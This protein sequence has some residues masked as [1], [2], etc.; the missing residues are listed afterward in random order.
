M[1]LTIF[2]LSPAMWS[3]ATTVA[4]AVLGTPCGDVALWSRA[5]LPCLERGQLHNIYGDRFE[6]VAFDL[7]RAGKIGDVQKAE[8]FRRE[9]AYTIESLGEQSEWTKIA[10]KGGWA[11]S[12]NTIF[13]EPFPSIEEQFVLSFEFCR[14]PPGSCILKG[15]EVFLEEC[16]LPNHF[17]LRGIQAL[18]RSYFGAIRVFISNLQI[19]STQSHEVIMSC[20][21]L[22]EMGIDEYGMASSILFTPHPMETMDNFERYYGELMVSRVV[23]KSLLKPAGWEMNT[24]YLVTCHIAEE[25]LSPEDF[26]FPSFGFFREYLATE[27][28]FAGL[29]G[30]SIALDKFQRKLNYQ[31]TVRTYFPIYYSVSPYDILKGV[32]ERVETLKPPVFP[33]LDLIQR[34]EQAVFER[35]P[36][37]NRLFRLNFDPS[38]DSD[39]TW[40]AALEILESDLPITGPLF[41]RYAVT[42]DRLG[43]WRAVESRMIELVHK[44][45][46]P[47]DLSDPF[48]MIAIMRILG[49]PKYAPSDPS[50]TFSQMVIAPLAP[51]VP[52]PQEPLTLSV[53]KQRYSVPPD[54][55][56]HAVL[57]PL[58]SEMMQAQPLEVLLQSLLARKNIPN[59]TRPVKEILN[60]C[61]ALLDVHFQNMQLPPLELPTEI[62]I[63]WMKQF[64]KPPQTE[65][66]N[67]Q[68]PFAL[69]VL[70]KLLVRYW[71]QDESLRQS[72]AFHQLILSGVQALM[73]EPARLVADFDARYPS[74]KRKAA[75]LEEKVGLLFALHMLYTEGVEILLGGKESPLSKIEN[76]KDELKQIYDKIRVGEAT[77]DE[78]V[79]ISLIPGR[80]PLDAF[81]AFFGRTCLHT[82]WDIQKRFLQY[83]LAQ[84]GFLPWRFVVGDHIRGTMMTNHFEVLHEGKKRKIMILHGIEPH[85]EMNLHP[86]DFIE[87]LE[88]IFLKIAKEGG[89]DFVLLPESGGMQSNQKLTFRAAMHRRYSRSWVLS[90]E[91]GLRFPQLGPG[92]KPEDYYNPEILHTQFLVVADLT[93]KS[94][95]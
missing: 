43:K 73:S 80:E 58:I 41:E 78:E 7:E 24:I 29:H 92:D 31:L 25:L 14:T 60:E 82:Q 70:A 5:V 2:Q 18:R 15:L 53:S 75:P 9:L 40:E 20:I 11:K 94:S 64:F 39:E 30:R 34:T 66:E 35:S 54:V 26:S 48:D 56:I 67:R 27:L 77:E 57:G 88:S 95:D 32:R 49:T 55:N 71:P 10:E 22:L 72:R 68:K 65:I 8:G 93:E 76:A 90:E 62:N 51:F 87:K 89:Y 83:G 12:L 44:R 74:A 38:N 1:A 37:A 61:A 3:S 91:Q 46:T 16:G 28:F 19:K 45:G 50:S 63:K 17:A 36:E 85:A 69:Q 23:G 4:Q 79:A 33:R 59:F 47:A 13:T 42:S 52:M 21:R 81:S 6:T 84:P 86:D